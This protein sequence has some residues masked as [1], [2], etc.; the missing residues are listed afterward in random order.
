MSKK[1]TYTEVLERMA[2]KSGWSLE[3]IQELKTH[4]GEELREA[5]EKD[6]S[7][8]LNGF[9]TFHMKWSDAREDIDPKTGKKIR[10]E[11]LNHISFRP[12][13]SVRR[14]INKEYESLEASAEVAKDGKKTGLPVWIY[15]ALVVVAVIVGGLFLN[16]RKAVEKMEVADGVDAVQEIVVVKEVPV[17]DTVVV[18]QQVEVVKEIAVVKEVPVWVEDV[19]APAPSS[20]ESSG[21]E[22][23]V[24]FV[25]DLPEANTQSPATIESSGPEDL[26]DFVSNLPE[27]KTQS[28]ATIES[29]GPEDMVD[30]VNDLPE[31]KTKSP[32]AIE[33]SGPEDLGDFVND[34]FDAKTTPPVAGGSTLDAD[35]AEAQAGM[36]K[37]AYEDSKAESDLAEAALKR[38]QTTSEVVSDAEMTRL[39]KNVEKTKK[40]A[41]EDL[42]IYMKAEQLVKDT[43][44]AAG[45]R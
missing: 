8:H 23:M 38:A 2:D 43:V 1:L 9:G 36:A 45:K 41:A 32:A 24:A 20:A 6:G 19:S 29:S 34:L 42:A 25:N 10:I 30:F 37:A 4:M 22:D 31:A 40:K 12:D 16:S 14:L 15:A 27:A 28:P 11:G 13:A 7:I 18:T 44:T 5:L 35:M 17:H 26:V 21:S 33:S 39:V 3:E